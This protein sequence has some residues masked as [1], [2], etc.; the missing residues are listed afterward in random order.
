MLA[1]KFI[2]HYFFSEYFTY[3]SPTP[4]Y[5]MMQKIQVAG[6]RKHDVDYGKKVS[7]KYRKAYLR[8]LRRKEYLKLRAILP[9]ISKKEKVSKVLNLSINLLLIKIVSENSFHVI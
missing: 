2:E 9:S 6:E 3:I 1:E 8:R 4:T 5:K 7:Q